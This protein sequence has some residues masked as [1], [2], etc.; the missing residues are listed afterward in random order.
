MIFN[1]NK[2]NNFEV[3]NSESPKKSGHILFLFLAIIFSAGI[4]LFFHSD[5]RNIPFFSA[6]KEESAVFG[7]SNDGLTENISK[8][9]KKDDFGKNRSS[10]DIFFENKTSI[11]SFQPERKEKADDLVLPN[12]HAS[13]I[14]DADSGTILHY[15]NGKERRQIAS[16]TKL[17]TAVLVMEKIK[18]LDEAVTIGEEVYIEGTKIGCPRSGYCIGQRLKIG[19]QIS[20]RSLLMAMLM[21]SANDAATALGKHISGSVEEF[22]KLMN[23]RARELG[24]RDSHFCT[25]SGLEIDGREEECYSTA[26]D[27]ARIAA[28]SMKY[29]VIWD[30]MRKPPQTIYSIDG[31]FSHD[32]LNTDQVLDQIPNCLGGKT[33]FTP[34]AGSSLLMGASDSTGKHKI[35]AVLLDDP[36]RWQD[37]KTM[38]DWTFDSCEWK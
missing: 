19:E 20:A 8:E 28:H 3:A 7:K 11:S 5:E 29:D 16:L 17:M 14:L 31:K 12:A 26:Y 30:I 10:E 34:L 38:I 23:D 2:N 6:K 35:V 4:F 33:G 24:L 32:I 18:D 37:I 22:S 36:Y 21:N 27:I 1:N 9:N 25:P 15:A 13:L